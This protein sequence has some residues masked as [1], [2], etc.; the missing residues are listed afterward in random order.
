MQILLVVPRYNLTDK[1]NY[2]Y[3]FPLGLSYISAVLKKEGYSVDCLN[4]NHLAGSTEELVKEKLNSKKYDFIG[5]G[6]NALAYSA[7]ER[8]FI[9]AKAHS[10]K[11]KTLLG[12]PIISSEPELI[13][14]NLSP[15]FGFLGEG[16]ETIIEFLEFF[17][18]NK[19]L[20]KVNGIIFRDKS[21]KT[22]R[23]PERK[24][25]Q[26]LDSIPFPD[27]EGIG[28]KEQLGKTHTNYNYHTNLS[29][30]PR[31]YNL[32][33]SRSCPY[34]CT[35]CFH[36]SR[37]R[38]RTLKNIMSE[39]KFCVKEYKINIIIMNDECF[40][41][42][43]KKLSDF[44]K[45]VKQ[46]QLEIGWDL[47]WSAQ[48]RVEAVNAEILKEMKDAGCG[49]ISYGFESFSPIVLKSMKKNI[50]PEQIDRAF[51]ATMSAKIPIQANFIFGDVAETKE[52]AKVTLD[53]YKK[54]CIGQVG[55][56][57]IQPYPNSLIYQ[58]CIKKGIIKDKITFIK[59]LSGDHWFNM[60]D[61]MTNEE[62]KNLKKEILDSVSKYTKFVVPFSFK[63]EGN[64]IYRIKAKCPFCKKENVYG[65]CLVNN[66]LS[67]GFVII[68]RGCG[69][70]FFIVS[71][72]QRIAYQHYSKIRTLRDLQK[73]VTKWLKT[74]V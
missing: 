70:R 42:D 72:L 6:G 2:D 17:S 53:Y 38:Q 56:G 64:K 71:H 5:T 19:N 66:K 48:L 7:I 69:M 25:I 34:Q 35:F 43:K 15:D 12:G 18:E 23:T 55:M 30:N 49:A 40:A 10:S 57:F 27:F 29:D 22:V 33:A 24:P 37:F 58:H 62:I 67:Y 8:I 51:K 68:C 14:E 74:K 50:T 11:P 9:A 59:N 21:K 13:F 44:C 32:L 1:P 60:T 4:L 54:H 46:L 28:L 31:V 26:N 47:K 63:K 36:D 45:E 3:S 39:L 16:E 52:T 65:N 41:I 61:K 73:R 20:E